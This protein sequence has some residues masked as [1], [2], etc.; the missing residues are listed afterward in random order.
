MSRQYTSGMWVRH[1]AEPD[2][3]LRVVRVDVDS[4]GNEVLLVHSHELGGTF[5]VADHQVERDVSYEQR[6]AD[7]RYDLAN[8]ID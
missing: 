8:D 6:E 1:V 7:A 2:L 5:K 3:P 4:L